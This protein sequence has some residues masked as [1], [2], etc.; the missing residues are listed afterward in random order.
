[1]SKIYLA[2]PFFNEKELKHVEAAERTLRGKGHLVFSP[3]EHQLEEVE[4]GSREWRTDVFRNDINHIKWCDYVVAIMTQGNYDDA[5]TAFEVGYAYALGKPVIVYNP[6]KNGLNLMV[7]DSLHAYIEEE[8][9]LLTYNF[10]T[11]HIK[12]YK[13]SVV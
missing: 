12:P 10:E 1:M 5:G 3:R 2:S 7:A 9:D 13:G 4:F 6:E 11:M 8:H